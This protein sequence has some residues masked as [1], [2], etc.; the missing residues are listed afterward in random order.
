[1]GPLPQCMLGYSPPP[2]GMGLKIPPGLGL[3]TPPPRCGSGD[4]LDQTPQPPPPGDLQGMLGY[5]PPCGQTDT[6]KNITFANFVC[7]W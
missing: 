6:C 3:E 1:M 5:H 4:P 2:P 7:G